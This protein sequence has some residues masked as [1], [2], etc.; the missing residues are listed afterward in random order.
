M[1]SENPKIMGI[2]KDHYRLLR[3]SFKDDFEDENES[4]NGSAQDEDN[5]EKVRRNYK[6]HVMEMW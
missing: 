1:A 5:I 4:K 2:R 3:T 6:G